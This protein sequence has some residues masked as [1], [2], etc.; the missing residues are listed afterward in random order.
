MVKQDKQYYSANQKP[1]L[2]DF[3]KL[4]FLT[5][6]GKGEPAGTEFSKAVEAPFPLA[7]GVKKI[8]KLKEMDFG[9]PKLE[10]LWWVKSDKPALEVPRKEWYWK[11]MIRMPDFVTDN[12]VDQAKIEVVNKK[13]IELIGKVQFEEITE[14]KCVQIMHVGPYSTESETL[15]QTRNFMEENEL[16]EN[17]R[18]HEIYISDPRKTDS[19]KMKTIL[20]QAVF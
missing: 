18:H 16:I 7:Y 10:G 12:I 2:R 1:E 19:L 20:R 9:V 11:L 6:S 3:A 8:C 15:R 4:T 14:G 13:G 17:G 5:L